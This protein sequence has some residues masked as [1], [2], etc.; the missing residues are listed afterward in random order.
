[1]SCPWIE[2][3]AK[4]DGEKTL[5]YWPTIWELKQRYNACRVEQ[6]NVLT[7]ILGGYTKHLEKS[8]RKL[9]GARARDELERM[10]ES[11]ISNSL[12]MIAGTLAKST[13]IIYHN[14]LLMTKSVPSLQQDIVINYVECCSKIQQ[15][16]QGHM[17]WVHF[18]EDVV[19]D[20][21]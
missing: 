21:E 10:Q 12:N 3:R 6:Y 5:K 15:D 7:D 17:L 8:V 19:H 11:V 2:I 16:H 13:R 9:L 1:M 14:Q 4:K 18:Q 20:F